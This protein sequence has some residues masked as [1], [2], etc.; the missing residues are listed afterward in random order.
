MTFNNECK[1]G[2]PNHGKTLCEECE[3]KETIGKCNKCGE[4]L[5]A[6]HHC[7]GVW[8]SVATTTSE[9]KHRNTKVIDPAIEDGFTLECTDCGMRLRKQE[10]KLGDCLDEAKATICGERQDVYGSPEDSFAVIAKYWNTY[11]LEK[12][13]TI[14]ELTNF[15]PK[16]YEEVYLFSAKDIAH[17]MV[18][19]KMARIQGQKPS[20]DNY[21]DLCGYAAI[22]ADRLG[23]GK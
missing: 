6:G 23:E 14:L 2:K 18:L 7:L 20:R 12:Q 9:C 1:C 11:M 22:A 13:K 15:A 19:F 21:V 3:M 5:T 17:M 4:T 8:N 16:Y 10:V